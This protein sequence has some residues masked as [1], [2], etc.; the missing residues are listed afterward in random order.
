MGGSGGWLDF[1]EIGVAETDTTPFASSLQISGNVGA[2][3][4][5]GPAQSSPG[6]INAGQTFD[7]CS[8]AVVLSYRDT[9]TPGACARH[10]TVT[11]TWT[12]RDSCGNTASLPQ[13]ITIRDG[14]LL[15]IQ[16]CLGT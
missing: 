4:W 11:R 8:G 5:G 7:P 3:V 13:T 9:F 10:G 1:H 15:N 12:A 6:Q 14:D 16:P 2:F